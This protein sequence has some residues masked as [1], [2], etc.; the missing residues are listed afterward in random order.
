[1][2]VCAKRFHP[3]YNGHP[4]YMISGLNSAGRRTIHDITRI[5]HC[6]GY[7]QPTRRMTVAQRLCNKGTEYDVAFLVGCRRLRWFVGETR[8]HGAAVKPHPSIFCSRDNLVR[9]A[10][11]SAC[12]PPPAFVHFGVLPA[13]CALRLPAAAV[14]ACLE[15]THAGQMRWISCSP[16]TSP[17]HPCSL[18]PHLPQHW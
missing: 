15:D 10:L 2:R 17:Q 5:K 16:S 1:M 18:P 14:E 7:V 8:T 4:H 6:M 12:R 11:R 3:H 9:G 13:P